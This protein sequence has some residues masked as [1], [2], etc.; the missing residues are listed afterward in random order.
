MCLTIDRGGRGD[1][2]RV[3]VDLEQAVRVTGQAV[4]DRIVRGIQ[5]ECVGR[6]PHGGTDR[7]VLIHFVYGCV[8]VG[9]SRDIKL[10]EIVDR[11]VERL[12]CR[13]AIA[14]RGLNRNRTGRTVSFT[15]D[16]GCRRHNTRISINLEQP[17]RVARQTVGDRV[18]G[19]VE[20]KRVGRQ[21]NR[22]TNGDILVDFVDGRVSIGWSRDIKLIEVVDRDVEGLGRR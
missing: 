11:D 5:V 8:G 14:G 7:H 6:D 17:I 12:G 21:P 19:C 22:R 2:T 3:G 4:S 9:R 1:F 13:R 16:R 15:V 20:I 18:V 10:I